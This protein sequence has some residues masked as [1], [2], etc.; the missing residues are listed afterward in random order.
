[1]FTLDAFQTNLCGV[2]AKRCHPYEHGHDQFQTNLCGVEANSPPGSSLRNS[3]FRRTFVG[4]KL[5]RVGADVGRQCFRRT[6][7]G[8]KRGGIKFINVACYWFQTN[9]CGVE[10]LVGF[11]DP[12]RVRLVSDEPLWG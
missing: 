1:M 2:E 8:L 3:R 5:V 12:L 4:L 6:F 7:V 11:G 10:A 9:L